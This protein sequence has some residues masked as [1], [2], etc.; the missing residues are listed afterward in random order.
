M[1]V[2]LMFFKRL[3]T[4]CAVTAALASAHA[5]A[6]CPF[7]VS[8]ASSTATAVADG[9][10][11]VRA[12]LGAR[13]GALIARSGSTRSSD[14]IVSELAANEQRLDVNGSGAFDEA[15]ALIITRYLMGVRGDALVAGGSGVGALR[16]TGADV[17]SFIDGGCVATA[18]PQRKKL[19]EMKA[20]QMALNN[21]GVFISV[22]DNVEID[23]EGIDLSWLEIQ[24]TLTCADR[25]LSV[26]SNWIIVHGGRFQCG[27]ALN[28][29][30]KNLTLTLTG[31][32][33]NEAA[34]GVGMGT[35]VLGVMHVGAQLRLY[36]E[37]RQGWSQ[38]AAN[39][40]VGVTSITLKEAVPS[41][42][43]GDQLVIAPSGFDAEDSD[44]VTVTSISGSTVNFSPA[45]RFAHWGTLQMFAGKTLDQRAA[46]GLLS[47]NIVVQ[48]DAQSETAKFGGHIMSMLNA[49][50]QLSGV[51]LRKM[52][53]RGRF[54]RY[55][56]HWHLAVDRGA[57]FIRNSSIHSSFQRAVVLHGTNKVSVEGNVAFDITNHAFVWAEDGNE[58]GNR[59]INNLA[60]LN[61]N[62]TE[63]EFAFPINSTLHANSTQAEFRSASFWG[64]S[65]NHTILGNIAAGSVD[66]LGFF[67][68]RFSPSKLGDSEGVGLVFEDNIA[69]SNYRPGAAGVAAEIYPEAT[70]GHG[71]MVTS[72]LREST[73]HVF[74][75]FTSYKNY[76]GTWLEDRVTVL[77]DSLLADNGTGTYLLRGVIDDVVIVGK[78]ANVMGNNEIPPKGGFGNNRKG[79][80]N[81]PSSHGGARAPIVK[82]VTVVDHDDVAFNS[83]VGDLAYSTRFDNV[84]LINTAGRFATAESQWYEYDFTEHGIDDSRGMLSGDGQPTTWVSRHSPTV[85][86]A[87]RSDRA[88][89]AFA[90][91]QAGTVAL[92][93]VGAPSRWTYLVEASGETHGLGQPWTFDAQVAHVNSGWLKA[94]AA[95][96]VVRQSNDAGNDIQLLLD[97][98]NGKSLELAWRTTGA[99]SSFTQNG[100][101]VTAA[102]SVAAMRNANVSQYFFDAAS[103]KLSAKLVGG[104]ATQTFA[105]NAP[106]IVTSASFAVGRSP[107]LPLPPLT[108]GF[109]VKRYATAE[110]N[111]LRQS[112]PVATPMSTT[113]SS[114]AQ[115]NATSSAPMIPAS[116]NDTTV[117]AAYVNAP[118][119]GLHR[120]SAPSI[121]GNVDVFVGTVWVTGTRSNLPTVAGE[122][123]PA[124]R[125]ESGQIW[126]QAGVH[127]I[128]L[129]FGRN[130]DYAGFGFT[131]K[132]WLRWA[133]PDSDAHNLVPLFR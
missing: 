123:D 92:R 110:S 78:S 85:T 63:A 101:A 37:N 20:E 88:A 11:L 82:S 38:L 60:V 3:F 62:P 77:Q 98:A 122:P 106:F 64:R 100:V 107:Q 33:S 34:L 5:Y 124:T 31:P 93:Y 128:T 56:M 75:K 112:I 18:L 91:P 43:E 111:F 127:P 125:D 7:A 46:V 131:P 58:S 99:P 129:V 10:L 69:H 14:A 119:S 94:G 118:S 22:F 103:K 35:K 120:F 66:G 126:L 19:S 102:A 108:A 23:K 105:M 55:P 8:G 84:R 2:A 47:R 52:G 115:L 97:A 104:A 57:D 116:S 15:D 32:S 54:G 28:P 74:R 86:N 117:F 16:K 133:L 50:T 87:C 25:N 65:F 80:L 21:G 81:V 132:T 95:Y 45:L 61:K 53:Q 44:R 72:N 9:L 76:G 114:A 70:F 39:A 83:D 29:F 24:G 68:D 26:A 96:E 73:D 42:R 89:N 27:T 71:L 49:S 36:G 113:S 121:G 30:N 1:S 51:E 130:S 12:A 90:C 59:F 79:A 109:D 41:W 67:F 17:Q 40:A 48:G 13:D 6:Q 4:A